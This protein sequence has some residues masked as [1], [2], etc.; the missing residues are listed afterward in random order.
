MTGEGISRETCD[1]LRREIRE[2]Y[3]TKEEV[4]HIKSEVLQVVES[5]TYTIKSDISEMIDEKMWSLEERI[6]KSIGLMDA[7]YNARLDVILDQYSEISKTQRRIM[8]G[9]RDLL[10]TVILILIIVI[11]CLGSIL[12][13]RSIDFGWFIP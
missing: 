9:N 11:V 5:K 13:G 6:N 3:A 10:V 1:T 4:R 2:C 8:K 7:N 12:L